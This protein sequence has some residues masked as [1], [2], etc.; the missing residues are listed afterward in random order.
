[1]HIA[2]IGAGRVG[3]TLGRGL[4]RAGH[5]I[6]YGVRAP[7]SPDA[8]GLRA[9]GAAVDTV[10]EAVAAASLVILAT[11]WPATRDAL[12]AAGDFGG[13]ILIDATNPIG[14]GLTLTHGKDDSGAE[15]VQRWA[16]GA[17]VVKAFHSTGAE[18]M[19]EPRFPGG[20]AM[21][22]VA[23]DEASDCDVVLG[24]CHDLGFDARR[25]G[26]LAKARLLEPMALVWITLAIQG[27]DRGF[28][29]GWL[30]R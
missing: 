20:A 25:L 1:M 27:G 28:A 29:F 26:P 7:N 23:G 11:P 18:I 6:H 19:A 3:T 2:I 8:D 30:H 24:L 21:M 10:A 5:T 13:R 22:L 9:E 4:Q 17:R 16:T 15:Q 14:P 12:Q